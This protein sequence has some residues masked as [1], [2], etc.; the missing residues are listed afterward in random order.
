LSLKNGTYNVGD[1]GTSQDVDDSTKKSLNFH[2]NGQ[3]AMMTWA[4]RTG[5]SGTYTRKLTYANK[6]FGGYTAGRL[7]VE[8]DSDFKNNVI[9]H[10][11]IDPNTGGANGGVTG[12]VN[13]VQSIENPSFS[14]TGNSGIVFYNNGV[15]STGSLGYSLTINHTTNS[16]TLKNGFVTG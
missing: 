12:T 16:R 1:I 14:L 5:N 9:Y 10:A 2:L 13:Y 3:G 11:Y 8:C 6:T 7:Y 15:F 4:A